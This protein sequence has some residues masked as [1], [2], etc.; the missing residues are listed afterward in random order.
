MTM[1][2][3]LEPRDDIDRFYATRKEGERRLVNIEDCVDG[4]IQVLKEYINKSKR[5]ITSAV[6]T[7]TKWQQKF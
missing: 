1:L 5:Q 7:I 3:A 4:A 2:K 6:I